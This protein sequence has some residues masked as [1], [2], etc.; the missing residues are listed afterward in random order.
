ML[1]QI[2]LAWWRDQFSKNASQWPDGEPLLALLH[3]WD[4]ERAALEHL[5]DGWEACGIANDGGVAL[6]AARVEALLA[7]ARLSGEAD[8]PDAVRQ[9]AL[10]WQDGAAQEKTPVLSRAMR[11]LMV[12][13]RL[14]FDSEAPPA[15]RLVRAMRS[16]LF[17]R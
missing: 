13:R 3:A 11:P 12:L 4:A 6:R 1:A 7:L 10:E 17:G 2:K 9:A 16:G 14:S 8:D 5:V 15:L